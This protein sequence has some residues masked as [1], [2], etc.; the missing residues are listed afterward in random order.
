MYLHTYKYNVL[1]RITAGMCFEATVRTITFELNA[2]TRDRILFSAWARARLLVI[3]RHAVHRIQSL[4]FL[5][6]V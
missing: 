5:A 4:N 3:I 6:S 1:K 2:G